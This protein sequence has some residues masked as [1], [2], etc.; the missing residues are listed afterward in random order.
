M[1]A[2]HPRYLGDL[3]LAISSFSLLSLRLW[4]HFEGIRRPLRARR[5]S[6]ANPVAL[7]EPWR[8]SLA[9]SPVAVNANKEEILVGMAKAREF[10]KIQD[11]NKDLLECSEALLTRVD[12]NDWVNCKGIALVSTGKGLGSPGGR[13]SEIASA[14]QPYPQNSDRPNSWRSTFRMDVGQNRATKPADN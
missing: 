5:G 6:V 8:I 3:P 1:N 2:L 13:S 11:E 4:P 7:P 9:C 10:C 12:Q 14:R